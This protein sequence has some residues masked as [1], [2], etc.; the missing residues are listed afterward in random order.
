MNNIGVKTGKN[1]CVQ[2]E[3]LNKNAKDNNN[4]NGNKGNP[5]ERQR[6]TFF[7]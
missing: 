5:N 2:C 7:S 1:S 4:D 3:I 6:I